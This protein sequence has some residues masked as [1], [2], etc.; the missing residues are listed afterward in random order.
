MGIVGGLDVHRSQ[1]TF[2][3][4]DTETGESARGRISPANR[5]DV[6]RWFDRFAGRDAHFALESTTGWRFVV[7]EMVRAGVVAHLAEPAD[8]AAMRGTKRRAKTDRADAQLMR[9]LLM[10]G[11][12]PES[13]IPPAHLLEM[14]SIVRLYK[15]LTDQRRG[16]CQ[17]IQAILFHNGVP[18]VA[19]LD[20]R[21]GRAALDAAEL[22]SASRNA[23]DTARRMIAALDAERDVLAKQ[24]Q[25]FARRQAGCQMLMGFHGIGPIFATA[26]LCELGDVSRFARSRQV[27]RHA[28]IDITVYSSD[29]KRSPGHL[30]RQGPDLLR[31]ALYEAAQQAS[32]RTSPDHKYYT[33]LKQSIGHGRATL[34]IARLLARRI[35]HALKPLGPIAVSDPVE[36]AA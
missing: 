17:R 11:R 24:I 22:S 14:R 30:S 1:I 13:W 8:T 3:W 23:V 20:T 18:A 6:R 2:D 29:A 15:T 5:L 21:Q 16:W 33:E 10:A 4:M 28:G 35:Y 26:I 19:N 9:D 25:S 7:E 31:W 27:V 36:N 34:S 12:L 32:R